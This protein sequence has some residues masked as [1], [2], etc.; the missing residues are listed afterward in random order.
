MIRDQNLISSR[1]LNTKGSGIFKAHLPF[2]YNYNMRNVCT[3]SGGN[4]A[5]IQKCSNAFYLD[6]CRII[7]SMFINYEVEETWQKKHT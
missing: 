4:Q 1:D 7:D 5:I 2:L 3:I 6:S